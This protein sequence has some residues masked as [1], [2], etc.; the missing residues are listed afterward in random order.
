MK[1]SLVLGILLMS[2][3]SFADETCEIKTVATIRNVLLSKLNE[4]TKGKNFSF[5]QSSFSVTQTNDIDSDNGRVPAYIVSFKTTRGSRMYLMNTRNSDVPV[6]AFNSPLGTIRKTVDDEGVPT[7]VECVRGLKWTGT[8]GSGANIYNETFETYA[9]IEM[10][11][12]E[13]AE[14][15]Q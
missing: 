12:Y 3:V 15:V 2:A 1:L 8:G 4:V 10:K 11:I 6:L 7:K 9:P 14:L 13:I 5:D